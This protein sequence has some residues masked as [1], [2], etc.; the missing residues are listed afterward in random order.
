M[1]QL[2]S[3]DVE[4]CICS[5]PVQLTL[6]C[7]AERR[8]VVLRLV[9]YSRLQ[10]ITAAMMSKWIPMS[11]SAICC[12]WPASGVLRHDGPQCSA[13]GARSLQIGGGTRELFYYPSGA[14][15]CTFIGTGLREGKPCT[16]EDTVMS[17]L[18]LCVTLCRTVCCALGQKQQTLLNVAASACRP[19]QAGRSPGGT[20]S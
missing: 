19:S 2:C 20:P 8:L 14:V 15:L 17:C 12:S 10:F 5:V 1:L 4:H 16:H 9:A 7:C 6:L 13:A 11:E 18:L 3:A